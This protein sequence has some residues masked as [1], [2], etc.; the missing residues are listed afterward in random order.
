MINKFDDLNEGELRE[1]TLL[2]LPN[3]IRYINRL[4][5]KE[6]ISQDELRALGMILIDSL[7]RFC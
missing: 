6:T 4:K 1:I 2:M 7:R 3:D 5:F